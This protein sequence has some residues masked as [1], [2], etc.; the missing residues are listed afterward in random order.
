MR[1]EIAPSLLSA[2][3]SK[4]GAQVEEAASAGADCLHFDIMDGHFVP[5]ITFGPMVVRAV[6]GL[7]DIP[8]IAHLM[9]TNPDDFIDEF[10]A[11]G[12]NSISVHVETCPHLHR[13]VQHIKSCGVKAAVAI[14]PATS[15]AT[16][17]EIASDV[18][19]VLVMTVNPG[20]GAQEFIEEMVD[21]IAR[22]RQLLNSTGRDIDLEVDGGINANTVERVVAVG[23]NVLIAGNSVFANHA[24]VGSAIAELRRKA[25]I[26]AKSW[27]WSCTPS[28]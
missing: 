6:R 10:A 25:E 16:L 17:E 24:G 14:N 26:S 18:D 1:I 21:K 12:A 9:I 7:T 15:I 11:A 19:A 13:T 5:N 8:F 4:L 27:N 2:D 28:T 20:F 22:V 23:A 3:F